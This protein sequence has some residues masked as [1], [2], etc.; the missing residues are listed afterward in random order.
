MIECAL[1]GQILVGEFDEAMPLGAESDGTIRV[2][3]ID[4]VTQAT[5]ALAQLAG[6][7]L[8]GENVAAIKCYLTGAQ[9]DNG[10]FTVRRILIN[11]KHGI[12]RNVYNAKVNIYRENAESILLGIEDRVLGKALAHTERSEHLRRAVR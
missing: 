8:S 2:D 10:E 9:L 12:T 5:S 11:D 7:E 6:L 3:S 4:F 1:P